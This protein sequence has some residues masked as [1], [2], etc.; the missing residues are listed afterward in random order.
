[1]K[2]KNIFIAS[3]VLLLVVFGVAAVLYKNQQADQA[4]QLITLGKFPAP[5]G[6]ILG[7]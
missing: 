6:G 4:A 7:G 3:A 1:M 2:Q 5:W